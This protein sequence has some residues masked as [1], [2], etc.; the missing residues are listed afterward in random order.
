MA[1]CATLTDP[2]ELQEKDILILHGGADISPL[3]YKKS[4]SRYTHA[5]QPSRRDV[6]EW[7]MLQRA[8]ELGVPIIGICRGG[9]MLCAAAGGIL[10]QH[11]NNHGGNHDVDTHDGQR[12]RVNSIH[13]QMMVPDGTE[14]K[15][16]AWTA[17]KLSDVYWSTDA[18]G[19]DVQI[20]VEKEPELIYFPKIKGMAIQW[21]PEMMGSKTLSTQFIV[22]EMANASLV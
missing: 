12:L 9:Q 5:D 20:T 22:K 13:H 1:Q 17:P 3:L 16:L 21:H 10:A 7:N 18:H 4:P 19:Q 2:K 6:I 8:I 15:L 11:V 14:H